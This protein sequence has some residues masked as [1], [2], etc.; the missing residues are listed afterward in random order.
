MNHTQGGQE[1]DI[2]GP[3]P[4]SLAW[5]IHQRL[6]IPSSQAHMEFEPWTPPSSQSRIRMTA[7]L[8]TASYK[9]QRLV[10]KKMVTPTDH[11]CTLIRITLQ[12][13]FKYARL[14]KQDGFETVLFSLDT[15]NK[16]VN[17]CN[18]DQGSRQ[19]MLWFKSMGFV[20]IEW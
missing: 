13:K 16:K 2:L 1:I 12:T 10:E 5:V 14:M 4:L 18:N 19:T 7:G 11:Y 15:E 8:E 6:S 9:L 20:H 17:T 3:E